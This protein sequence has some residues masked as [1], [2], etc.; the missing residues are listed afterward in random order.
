MVRCRSINILILA[1]LICGL[2]SFTAPIAYAAGDDEALTF[3]DDFAPAPPVKKRG[4]P[5][6]W[7]LGVLGG[8]GLAQ[9]GS[10]TFATSDNLNWQTSSDTGN[11]YD[12]G[13]F[14]TH[15]WSKSS[16]FRAYVSYQS[17]R[18]TGNVTEVDIPQPP[19]NEVL[20]ETMI[21][22]GFDV[23]YYVWAK[24]GLWLGGGLEYARGISLSITFDG[25]DVPTSAEDYTNY[26]KLS[27]LVGW[28]FPVTHDVYLAPSLRI[29]SI[30]TEKPMILLLQTQLAIG[31][32]L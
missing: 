7:S 32:R 15:K 27:G 29:G 8:W 23:L 13:I 31:Y 30:L 5:S 19:K 12:A 1:Q 16:F 10:K 2:L 18:F 17:Y 3:E 24:H 6:Q 14:V 28:D 21:A 20:S 22:G 4:A 9:Q 11:T 26:V 25:V